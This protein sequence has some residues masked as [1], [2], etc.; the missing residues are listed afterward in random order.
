MNTFGIVQ[1]NH[2]LGIYSAIEAYEKLN[3]KK[4]SNNCE[5]K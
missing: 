3:H 1:S 5:A 2:A 4:R